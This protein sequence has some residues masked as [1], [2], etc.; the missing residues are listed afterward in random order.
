MSCSLSTGEALGRAQQRHNSQLLKCALSSG[1]CSCSKINVP[2]PT[3]WKG[4]QSWQ[5]IANEISQEERRASLIYPRIT[6]RKKSLAHLPVYN[7]NHAVTSA[8][9]GRDMGGAPGNKEERCPLGYMWNVRSGRTNPGTL[10][11]PI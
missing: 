7:G 2:V 5:Q 10:L 11:G 1:P 4:A 8:V 6:E 9:G 3:A